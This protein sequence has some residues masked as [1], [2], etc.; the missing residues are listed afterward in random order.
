VIRVNTALQKNNEP[1]IQLAVDEPGPIANGVSQQTVRIPVF[2]GIFGENDVH[3]DY[4][5]INAVDAG[6]ESEIITKSANVVIES[7]PQMVGDKPPDVIRQVRAGKLGNAMPRYL[8]PVDIF[9]L[10]A[11]KMDFKGLREVF[12]PF[13][14]M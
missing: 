2:A 1:V 3:R 11:I 9:D 5:G 14:N 4:V 10:L 8:P 6:T 13:H 12:Q 7:T